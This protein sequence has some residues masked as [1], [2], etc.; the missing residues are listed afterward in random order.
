MSTTAFE[1]FFPGG[2]TAQYDEVLQKMG[3]TDGRVPPG[4]QFHW[5]AEVDGGLRVVDVWDSAEQFQAFAA[6]QIGPFTAAAGMSEPQVT[7]HEVYNTLS[8]G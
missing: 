8:A 6:E 7:S 1:M 5:V 2:T 4:A 3:L